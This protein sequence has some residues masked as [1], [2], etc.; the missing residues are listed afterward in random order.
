MQTKLIMIEGIP[1]SGK[2]STAQYIQDWVA[3]QGLKAALYLEDA[4]NHPVDLDNLSYLDEKQYKDF[5]SRFNRYRSV[6][7]KITEK[8]DD[9]YLVFYRLWGKVSA[10][11]I[12]AELAQVLYAYDAHDSLPPEKYRALSLERWQKFG[13]QAK[14]DDTVT[15][16]ECCLLQNP[17]TIFVGKHHQPID[18]VKA[19]ILELAG[20]V[21]DLNPTLVLLRAGSA[22]QTLQRV[23]KTRPQAWIEG[24]EAYITGQGYGKAHKLSGMEGVFSFYEMMQ[25]VEEE[26][27][28][29]LDWNKV[30]L[31]NTNWQWDLA[32]KEIEAFLNKELQNHQSA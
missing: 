25:E 32:N 9:G 14:T 22:K 11:K 5:I 30:L 20:F 2:T 28:S 15:I 21:E 29:K 24:V 16:F 12:P 19:L 1:G 18:Q 26:V 23:I 8:S 3:S 27:A 6:I 17:L 10:E 4:P 7:E 31:D 13:A